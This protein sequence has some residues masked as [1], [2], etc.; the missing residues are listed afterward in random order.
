MKKFLVMLLAV[1]MLTSLLA[2]CANNS[3]TPED[4]TKA[5]EQSNVLDNLNVPD[6]TY[7]GKEFM[8]LTRDAA[9]WT[10]VDIYAEEINDDPINSA[11]YRRNDMIQ[12]K[13]DFKILET[14]VTDPLASVEKDVKGGAGEFDAIVQKLGSCATIATKNYLHNLRDVPYLDFDQTW[15]DQKA[16]EGLSIGNK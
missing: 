2:G 8:F 7:G 3:D 15:W 16:L 9:E 14:Q 5:E 4:T 12:S 11:V 1:L 13:Y 10:T 6:I